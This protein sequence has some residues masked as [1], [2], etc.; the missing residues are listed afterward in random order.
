MCEATRGQPVSTSPISLGCHSFSQ[1]GGTNSLPTGD[2][3]FL[4]ALVASD[5]GWHVILPC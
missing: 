2:G 5:G 4:L 1:K 3:S